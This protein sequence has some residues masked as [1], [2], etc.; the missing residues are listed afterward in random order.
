MVKNV[1]RSSS[2]YSCHILMKL[3]HLDRFFEKYHNTKFHENPSGGSQVLPCGR[4]DM[5][6]LIAASRNFADARKISVLR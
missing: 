1:Y 6:K 4:T 5:T 2:R 3:E